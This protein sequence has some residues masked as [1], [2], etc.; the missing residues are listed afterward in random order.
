MVWSFVLDRVSQGFNTVELLLGNSF[1]GMEVGSVRSQ[2]SLNQS[3][4]LR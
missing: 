2:D 3:M 1:K 4:A